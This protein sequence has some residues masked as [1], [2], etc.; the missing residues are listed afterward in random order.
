[1]TYAVEHAV[2]GG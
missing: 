1:M 2:A